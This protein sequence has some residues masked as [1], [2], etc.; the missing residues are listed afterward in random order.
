MIINSGTIRE[1]FQSFNTVF[2]K[3]FHEMEAQY[4]RVAMEVPS[5]TRDE[6]YAWLGAVPSMREWIGDREIKNLAAYG[7]TIR[8]KDF[9][10][11]VT[12]PRND[13]ED[14]CIGVYKPVFQD[15]AYS[16]RKHPDKLVFGL[17]PRSFTEKCFD[18]KPFIS[19]DHT[20]AFAG[21]KAKAQSNK[22]TYKLVPESYGAARTQMMCLVND[23]GEVMN[24]VPDLLVVAPQKEAKRGVCLVSGGIAG[25]GTVRQG[26]VQSGGIGARL[27][28][29]QGKL[30][31]LK[32]R[33]ADS[34]VYVL[35]VESVALHRLIIGGYRS[36][37]L[38][39]RALSLLCGHGLL[40]LVAGL[41]PGVR[42]CFL[43]LFHS[44]DGKGL[45]R[46]RR[47]GGRHQR[48]QHARRQAHR[49]DAF[50]HDSV[51]LLFDVRGRG[52]RKC[53]SIPLR[54]T[55]GSRRMPFGLHTKQLKTGSA[56]LRPGETALAGKPPPFGKVYLLKWWKCRKI[57]VKM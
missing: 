2:N 36:E 38:L 13:L 31:L 3:A 12:V 11:T 45:L 1:A 24:I 41:R 19:D 35:T 56:G 28:I 21:H 27:H 17:F 6:N 14:D 39:L 55:G 16:A 52:R 10:A 33:S 8:N 7:Y 47:K 43:R 37:G 40:W 25:K 5:E 15:L 23:Q 32:L 49:Q 29:G 54:R 44:G 50:L 51:F 57:Y 22:G 48:Q 26:Q 20:P 30:S 4:P 9:E 34:Q 42:A 46:V 53:V 18:G